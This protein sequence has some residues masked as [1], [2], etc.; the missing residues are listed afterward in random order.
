MKGTGGEAHD[1]TNAN[2]DALLR[3]GHSGEV[4]I[5]YPS[6]L[7][8]TLDSLLHAVTTIAMDPVNRFWKGMHS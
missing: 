2:D 8:K 1:G 4:P 3:V 7:V 5:T 6:A